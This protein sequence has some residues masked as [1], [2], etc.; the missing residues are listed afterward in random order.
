MLTR[1]RRSL[2]VLVLC[3]PCLSVTPS[4]TL[5]ADAP[6][7]PRARIEAAAQT[8][9]AAIQK[10]PRD[11]ALGEEGSL[12]LPAGYGFIPKAEAAAMLAAQGSHTGKGFYGL[13]VG[14]ELDGFLVLEYEDAGYV[15][16]EDAR[17]WD[18]TKLLDS[19]REGT[20]AG[21]EERRQMGVP[22][23]SVVGWVE[24]PNYDAATHR[25]VWSASVRTK[26]AENRGDGVN[27]NTYVLGR[28]GYFSMNL[29][30]SLASIDKEKPAARELL[31]ALDFHEGKRYADFNSS[32]DK[33]A[34]YGLAALIGGIAAKKLGLLATLGIFLAKFW[35]V[36]ALAFVGLGA[37]ARKFFGKKDAS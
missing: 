28:E 17:D 4:V 30:T 32:T 34:E 8:A 25:L 18:A 15:K 37:G 3:L 27:Y 9:M 6:A 10:G 12:R 7:D 11:I 24:A 35:K 1:L 36:G 22:E 5:A 16:D 33:V 31:A 26:G 21:N 13:I 19:L 23:Y 20:E 29:V 2:A 14:E